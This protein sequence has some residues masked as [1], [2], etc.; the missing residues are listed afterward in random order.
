VKRTIHILLLLGAS[1][2][3]LALESPPNGAGNPR[4]ADLLRES[5]DSVPKG[6]ILVDV[7]TDW[8]PPC[9]GFHRDWAQR[10]SEIDP[11]LVL[12]KVNAE[13]E[14]GSQWSRA[15]GVYSF[16]TFVLYN[17]AHDEVDRWAGYTG[18]EQWIARVTSSRSLPSVDAR[19]TAYE[20]NPSPSVALEL[21]SV[22]AARALS[23]SALSY[24]AQ[25]RALSGSDTEAS[26][27]REYTILASAWARDKS[28]GEQLKQ[29]A[30]Q[31]LVA[32]WVD[33]NLAYDL[34]RVTKQV[35]L[36]ESASS[37]YVPFLKLASTFRREGDAATHPA[38]IEIDSLLY[39]AQDVEA[40]IVAHQRTLPA[41]WQ[42]SLPGAM[43]NAEWCYQNRIELESARTFLEDSVLDN[44]PSA[45]P[46]MLR[47]AAFS[48]LGDICAE[49]GDV[50]A[51]LSAADS[52]VSAEPGIAEIR[53]QRRRYK[54]ILDSNGRR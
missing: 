53:E 49:L 22:F 8:C 23:D 16:P 13:T 36:S 4:L 44:D 38:W 41:N 5:L 18:W 52:A 45:Y 14:R 33:R 6:Y 37:T 2:A 51:A 17:R 32:P 35:A 12:L 3:L 27:R 9:A 48:T 34:A 21:A 42:D 19:V 15:E 39:V 20:A 31:M 47:A 29:V 54:L 26:L 11:E 46:P 10:G 40:A 25:A 1:V 30:R 28:Y 43:A 50:H 24:V 7:Y